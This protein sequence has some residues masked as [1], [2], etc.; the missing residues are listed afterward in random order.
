MAPSTSRKLTERGDL[1]LRALAPVGV[2]RPAF[3][4]WN[5]A[6]NST[7]AVGTVVDCEGLSYRYTGA[8]TAIGD[9][10]GWVDVNGD[11]RSWGGV[12]GSG[13]DNT[14]ALTAWAAWLSTQDPGVV[15]FLP[16]GVWRYSSPLIFSGV[17]G[18]VI[19][20]V[21]G[22]VIGGGSRL[23]YIGTAGDAVNGSLRVLSCLNYEFRDICFINRAAAAPY[24]V[25][26][27][28]NVSPAL[29]SHFVRFHQCSFIDAGTGTIATAGVL[30]SSA[31]FVVLDGCNINYNGHYGVIC[32]EDDDTTLISGQLSGAAIRD[33]MIFNDI[34]LYRA[35]N[36]A[37]ERCSFE[38]KV[39]DGGA[40]CIVPLGELKST[41]I[42]IRN[43]SFID[44]GAKTETRA[45]ITTSSY[46]GTTNLAAGSGWEITGNTFRNRLT[47]VDVM[48]SAR[49]ASNVFMQRST[50]AANVGVRINSGVPAAASV[51]IDLTNDFT[52][53]DANN[54]VAVEDN[55][56]AIA[57][58]VI[59]S[60]AAAS[61]LTM[62]AVGSYQTV[63]TGQTSRPLR[64]GK[65][66]ITYTMVV[67]VNSAG[68]GNYRAQML[69]G[70]VEYDTVVRTTGGNSAYITLRCSRIVKL[71]GTTGTVTCTLRLEQS[72]GTASLVRALTNGSTFFQIEELP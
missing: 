12:A 13:V 53:A 27:K 11:V 55:R 20:G 1:V 67:L 49:L 60:V 61:D 14:A 15:G 39:I 21:G 24:H 57:D 30:L 33:C 46:A 10:P 19:R 37:I 62:P 59:I 71:A 29:S 51:V 26:V 34:G 45:A 48:G 6:N 38:T 58:G 40:G 25:Q 72:S 17:R 23:E 32:G 63:L 9:L 18:R 3:V 64:G 35:L 52:M 8:G 2:T 22:N 42:A 7:I 47:G 70:G 69:I 4:A 16:G 31:K 36:V 66:Q 28:A 43:N 56:A 65:Y 68:A 50:P 5:A 54:M 41:A 44:D